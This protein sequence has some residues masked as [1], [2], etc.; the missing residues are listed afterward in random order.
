MARSI[1]I[2]RWS[3]VVTAT[4][5][6]TLTA[7]GWLYLLGP[8]T[9]VPGPRLAE[10]LPLDELAHHAAV[11]LA[12][13]IVVWSAAGAV[14]GL[15]AR[16]TRL[17][18]LAVGLI[19]ALCVGVLEYVADAVSIAV[20]RQV[21]VQEAFGRAAGLP[22]IYLAAALAGLGGAAFARTRIGRTRAPD[23]LA[24]TV[25]LTGALDIVRAVLP[26]AHD[27][28]VTGL[29]PDAVVSVAAALGVPVGVGLLFA[30]R[31]LGRRQRRAWSIAVALLGLSVALHVLHGFN[32]GGVLATFTLIALVAARR[33]FGQRAEPGSQSRVVVR[34]AISCSAIAAFG[35][36]AVWLNRA[37]VDQPFS[38][39]FA[40]RETLESAVGLGTSAHLGT[41]FGNWF[42]LTVTILAVLG[43]VWTLSAALAPW[44]YRHR[45]DVHE[46]ELAKA[47]VA[48]WGT[49]TLAPF[50]LRADKSYFFADDESGFVAYKVV[51]GVAIVSGDPICSSDVLDSL[52]AAFIAFARVRG[53]R[54]AILGASERNLDCY[55]QHGLLALYHGDE[56]VL[57]TATFSLEGRPIRKVRQ[58]AQRLAREGYEARLLHPGEI[59]PELRTELEAIA[60]DWRGDQPQKG[61]VM[62]LDTLFR[63]EDEDAVF[64]IGF[65]SNG[66]AAGFIHFACSRVGGALSLS[67]MPRLRSTPNGF[68]EWLVCETAD[69]A[70]DHGY[71]Q[72]SLNF[73]PFAALLAPDADL[74][75]LQ[76]VERRAL[77]SLKGHFQL[78]NLLHFNRK[79]FPAW[80]RRFVVYE[81]RLDLPRVGLAALAAEAYLTL[82]RRHS[83]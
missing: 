73:A 46:Y 42:P 50:V 60:S 16:L 26:G 57:E 74:G 61:F 24:T 72:I 58:S 62:A 20:V 25:A 49:D 71:R 18:R 14:L 1:A 43:V 33:D 66:C 47:L 7:T 53:W 23:V 69:W 32:D 30:A 15:V 41:P 3:G 52:V 76:R 45:E 12:V 6:V 48:A 9:A 2:L 63:L 51:G 64:A 77:L 56:A 19:L 29:A 38:I 55:R 39:G 68:N 21:P 40:A 75:T 10:V 27:I 59:G 13:F 83:Q 35:V 31:G 44:R 78:D 82:P 34:A 37:A 5:L 4:A 11:P 28:F 65:D 80:Q 22:S 54:V 67:S 79:F 36:A 70:R 81:R 17:D 8:Q